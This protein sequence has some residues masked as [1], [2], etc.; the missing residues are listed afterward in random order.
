[1]KVMCNKVL[2]VPFDDHSKA[3]GL[4]VDVDDARNFNVFGTVL[5]VP[6]KLFAK[7]SIGSRSIRQRDRYR[8]LNAMSLDWGTRQELKA[9][10]TVIFHYKAKADSETFVDG[11][12]LMSYDMIIGKVENGRIVPING[13]IMV[14]VPDIVDGENTATT[15]GFGQV[16]SVSRYRNHSYKF[17]KK[18]DRYDPRPGE[19]L[20]FDNK[21]AYPIEFGSHAEHGKLVAIKRK[22]IILC[23]LR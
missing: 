20:L 8:R 13:N 3:S 19:N 10:D 23:S 17:T 21:H 5:A 6:K 1:M 15:D 2:I 7:P 18:M 9:G 16:V 22:D 11:T 14:S 12:I 4:I